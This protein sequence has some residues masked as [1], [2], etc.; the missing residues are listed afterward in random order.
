[1]FMYAVTIII[2]DLYCI[3]CVCVCNNYVYITARADL[4]KRFPGILLVLYQKCQRL[5]L[6]LVS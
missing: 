5:L 2:Y 3:N 6:R 4:K 1:M